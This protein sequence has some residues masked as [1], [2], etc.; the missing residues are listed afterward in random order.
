MEHLTINPPLIDQYKRH[1]HKLRVQLTDACNFRCFYCMPENIKFKKRNDLLSSQEIVDICTILNEF[2]I[3]EM[4]LTGGEP[5]ISKDFEKIV[6]GLSELKLAKFGLTSNGFILEKKLSFLKNTNCQSINIS[7]DSLNEERF[8]QIT[9]GNYFK[10]VMSSILKAREMDFNIKLNVVLFKGIN[11]QEVF[12]FMDFSIKHDIEIRFL[13]LMKIGPAYEMNPELFISAGQI[14][15]QIKQKEQLIKQK[16][17]V[18]STSF[19][20]ISESGAKIGFIASESKPFC[21]SCS[22]L[23]LSATGKLRACLMS[24]AGLDLKDKKKSEYKDILYSVM[25]MKPSGRIEYIEQ[26][27]NQIGG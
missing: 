11:D 14:L 18:D 8:N 2:G 7:L 24:E 19:N 25:S 9:K 6:L 3:D 27:M 10:S 12:D 15:K 20:Y 26:S 4:R 13:E 1:I 23:R 22:R 16:V 17:S 5:T 21:G